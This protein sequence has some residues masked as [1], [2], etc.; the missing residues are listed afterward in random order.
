M[1]MSKLKKV[2]KIKV[3]EKGK[4]LTGGGKLGQGTVGNKRKVRQACVNSSWH[5]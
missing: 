2:K 5:K 1:S 4:G 3:E